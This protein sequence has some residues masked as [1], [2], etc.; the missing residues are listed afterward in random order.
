MANSSKRVCVCVC[1]YVFIYLSIPLYLFHRA[2]ER[3]RTRERIRSTFHSLF[4]FFLSL[5][6]ID[7]TYLRKH[8]STKI[9]TTREATT[10]TTEATETTTTTLLVSLLHR[11]AVIHHCFLSGRLVFVSSSFRLINSFSSSS[12]SLCN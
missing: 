6:C 2:I 4:F 8:V 3:E 12:S 7:H 10:T 5:V 1:M 11:L 9:I